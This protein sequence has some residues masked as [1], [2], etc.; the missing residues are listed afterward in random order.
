MKI[1]NLQY[2]CLDAHDDFHSALKK[3]SGKFGLHDSNNIDN[4]VIDSDSD[5][6]DNNEY[7]NL[8]DDSYEE[9]GPV[10]L[11]ALRDMQQVENIVRQAGWLKKCSGDLIAINT[12]PI[13]VE[14]M[15]PSEWTS[16]VKEARA[17]ALKKKQANI[18][19]ISEKSSAKNAGK[20][21]EI[22]DTD[23]F[24]YNFKAKKQLDNKIIEDV[25]QEFKLNTE[26]L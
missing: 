5:V 1:F 9:A 15:L 6:S 14:N 25:A 26:Q 7:N 11:K 10:H 24:K 23:Y 18:P 13:E 12:E 19:T 20:D 16:C 22:V 21:V 3:K 2:K 17:L 4:T 8:A